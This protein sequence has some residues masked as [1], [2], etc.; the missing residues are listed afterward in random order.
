MIGG[1][2]QSS[3]TSGG[4]RRRWKLRW[5]LR[6]KLCAALAVALTGC[7]ASPQE[8]HAPVDRL[9]GERLNAR[10]PLSGLAPAELDSLL[11]SPLTVEVAVRIALA[12]SPRL[13]AAL[14]ELDVAGGEVAAALGLGPVTIEAKARFGGDRDEYELDAV[15]NVLGLIAA[16]SRR[17]AANAELA[18]ARATAAA[19]ALR[20]AAKVEIAFNDLAA[21]E[22]DVALRRTGLAAAEA[23]ATLRER[24]HDAGNTTDLA[25][26]R[27]REAREQAKIDLAR[28]TAAATAPRE[29]LNALLG[30]SGTRTTWTAAASLRAL[31]DAAPALDDLEAR[32]AAASLELTAGRDRRDAAEHRAS[33]ERLRTFV[34]ELGLGV[35]IAAD[36]GGEHL[37]VGPAIQL[38]LPLFD[39]RSGERAKA[40]ALVRRADHELTAQTAE[41]AAAARAAR[42]TARAAYQE[43]RQL[44]DQVVPL[45][46]Q[47]LDQTLAHYNAMDADPFALILARRDVLDGAHQLADATRRYWN[48]MAEV[49]APSR[50]AMLGGNEP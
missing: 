19:A 14:D 12:Q 18:A 27:D 4:V 5:T 30:L 37:G 9:V 44:T 41:L 33:T 15:Q 40:N 3:D 11:A 39:F 48:A 16:P 34:P 24:M 31:P 42:I 50:G 1:F 22:Q 20:L 13:R 26:A 46:Q 32:A 49:T 45:R 10:A 17:A 8:L 28:A 2:M 7:A 25:L 29:A 23:A 43:A 21:A 35:A 47:I 36:T 6:W 38:G